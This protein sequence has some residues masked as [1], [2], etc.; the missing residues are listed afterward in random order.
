MS[1]ENKA[2]RACLA[3]AAIFFTAIVFSME[4]SASFAGI[5]PSRVYAANLYPGMVF[6]KD[7]MLSKGVTG[8]SVPVSIE[9]E[10]DLMGWLTLSI[11]SIPGNVTQLPSELRISVPENATPGEYSGRLN[12]RFL[13]GSSYD[14]VLPVIIKLNVTRDSIKG[15]SVNSIRVSETFQNGPVNIT[16]AVENF[17]NIP[18]RPTNVAIEISDTQKKPLLYFEERDFAA[19]EPFSKQD[20]TFLLFPNLSG[21]QYWAKITAYDEQQI[22][23][24]ENVIF[25][26]HNSTVLCSNEISAPEEKRSA[27]SAAAPFFF[28]LTVVLWTLSWQKLRRTD[29]ACRLKKLGRFRGHIARLM[30]R[31]LLHMRR[32]KNSV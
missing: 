17:G 6:T 25:T 29:P 32:K 10:G 5:S 12:V 30:Q 3:S 26:V 4:V 31:S 27:I 20:I 23:R 13:E 15:F 1:K 21:G 24:Q 14:I 28:F 2:T 11:D 18:A 16:L 8:Q 22:V 19:A 9:T 7:I